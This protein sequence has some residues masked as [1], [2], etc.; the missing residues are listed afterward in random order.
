MTGLGKPIWVLKRKR[1]MGWHSAWAAL[2]P[3]HLHKSTDLY[4]NKYALAAPHLFFLR[5]NTWQF[6]ER[7]GTN[8]FHRSINTNALGP[9]YTFHHVKSR[10]GRISSM[11]TLYPD[12]GRGCLFMTCRPSVVWICWGFTGFTSGMVTRCVM[13]LKAPLKWTR[14]QRVASFITAGVGGTQCWAAFSFYTFRQ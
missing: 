5:S 12:A 1:V 9:I 8:A 13:N 10:R 14:A 6:A 11:G 3:L 2:S 4:I 7:W